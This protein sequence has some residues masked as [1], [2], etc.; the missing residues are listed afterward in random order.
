MAI[1]LVADVLALIQ[2]A[3]DAVQVV[4]QKSTGGSGGNRTIWALVDRVEDDQ[5]EVIVANDASSGISSSEI[6]VDKDK[7]TV[8][9]RHGESAG[10]RDIA[11]FR[12]DS[13]ML[14]LTVR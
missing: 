2:S 5:L 13:G 7:L 1:D 6:N 10:T 4:Y 11:G 8:A 14:I 9:L 3:P 12:H